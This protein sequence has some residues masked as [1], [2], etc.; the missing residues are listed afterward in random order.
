M[1]SSQ[2]DNDAIVERLRQKAR[3]SDA[4]GEGMSSQQIEWIAADEIERLRGELRASNDAVNLILDEC[5][6]A[7]GSEE[8]L[9]L[10]ELPQIIARLRKRLEIDPQHSY[11]GIE[12]RDETIRMQ[13][14]EIA[15][16]RSELRDR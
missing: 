11:D 2:K 16:L 13:N 10:G 7:A 15:R 12:S 14:A 5:S 6:K 8:G 3:G 1:T 4:R 9:C